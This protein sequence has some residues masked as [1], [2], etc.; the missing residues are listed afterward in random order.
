M[1][2]YEIRQESCDN[3]VSI[4]SLTMVLAAN[5]VKPRTIRENPTGASGSLW[6]GSLLQ[7]CSTPKNAVFVELLIAPNCSNPKKPVFV[8]GSFFYIQNGR[9]IAMSKCSKKLSKEII[10]K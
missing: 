5:L 4:S 9:K 2:F 3:E 6:D 8:N 7:N 1:V 10:Q